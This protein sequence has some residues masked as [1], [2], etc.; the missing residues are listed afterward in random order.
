MEALQAGALL[1]TCLAAGG[2]RHLAGKGSEAAAF[3]RLICLRRLPWDCPHS[4]PTLPLAGRGL[5]QGDSVKVLGILGHSW[6]NAAVGNASLRL[7]GYVQR[8]LGHCKSCCLVP[9]GCPRGRAWLAQTRRRGLR[10][11]V[12]FSADTSADGIHVFHLCFRLV[13][14]DPGRALLRAAPRGGHPR[15]RRPGGA[16]ARGGL[17]CGTGA[18]NAHACRGS[19]SC[20]CSRACADVL[21]C[22]PH[23]RGALRCSTW[24]RRCEAASGTACIRQVLL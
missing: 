1:L 18:G 11:H 23:G 16:A 24:V 19:V 21:L 6:D 15:E 5:Q 8:C 20:C 7:L 4:G 22:R 9:P 13:C 10:F 17:G 14:C 3:G 12:E 2:S